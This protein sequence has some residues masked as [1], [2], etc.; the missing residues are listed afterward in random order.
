MQYKDVIFLVPFI[1]PIATLL[2]IDPNHFIL[3]WNEGAG[4]GLLFA[5]IFLTMEL[6]DV[7]MSVKPN[8]S[9]MRVSIILASAIIFSSYF[10]VVYACG[11]SSLITKLGYGLG[12]VT[13]PQILSWSRVLDYLVYAVYIFMLITI[14]LGFKSVKHFPTPIVFLSGMAFILLLDATFPY[15]S[16]KSLQI[17]VQ[18][19]LAITVFLLRVV[20]VRVDY[21]G[22]ES[23]AVWGNKGFLLIEIYW[24]CAGILSMI[25]YFLVIVILM[26]KL[27]TSVSR[28]LVYAFLGAVGTFFVNILRIFLIIY[29]GAFIDVNLR[30]FHE[31]IGEV[32]FTV[33]II[34]Y[35]LLVTT[36]DYHLKGIRRLY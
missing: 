23:L 12:Y 35:L 30:M 18:P 1:F 29:Y 28:K 9:V 22:G 17:M 26:L 4:A 14:S 10:Y 33:W 8:F 34:F 5:F 15:G 36:V 19:I 13:K 6:Y 16:V 11:Q 21:F 7:R 2:F 3:G 27:Q 24:Q 20:N 25:I 32:L 31:S